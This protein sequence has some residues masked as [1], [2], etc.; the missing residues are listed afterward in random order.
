MLKA[1]EAGVEVAGAG[2]LAPVSALLPPFD[3]FDV[4]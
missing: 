4:V 2:L 1:G 3:E